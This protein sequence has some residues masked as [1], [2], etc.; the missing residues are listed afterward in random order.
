MRLAENA[1]EHERVEVNVQLQ[2]TAKALDHGHRASLAVLGATRTRGPRVEGE[3]RPGMHAQHRAA[4]RVIPGEA[5]AQ[6]IRERQPPLAD[7]YPRQHRVDKRGGAFGHPPSSTARTEPAS[8][9]GEGHETLE[10]AVRAPQPRE[11]VAQYGTGEELSKLL[12]YE[13]REAVSVAA[14][15]D[16]PEKGLQVLAD[17][18]VEHGVLGVA[19]LIRA[20]MMA[21]THG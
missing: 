6:A 3:Q 12:L 20:I 19:G 15:R 18:G 1:V 21:H 13:A 7:R 16:F 17:D 9:T 4:Q 2:S 5:V 11:P 14:V 8:L 10:R